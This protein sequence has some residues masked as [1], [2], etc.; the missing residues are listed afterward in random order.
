MLKR[1]LQ[2]EQDRIKAAEEAAV[3]KAAAEAARAPPNSPVVSPIAELSDGSPSIGSSSSKSTTLP[4]R[5]Q[6][7]IS[8][9][10]LHRPPF[11]HKLDLSAATLRLKPDDPMQVLQSGLASPVTLA[12]RSSISLVPPDF[13]FGPGEVEIDLTLDDEVPVNMASSIDPTLGSS[14]DKPIE[15]LDLDMEL[16]G[17]AVGSDPDAGSSGLNV[18]GLTGGATGAGTGT[19]VDTGNGTGSAAKQEEALDFELLRAFE[20]TG[21]SKA[22]GDLLASLSELGSTATGGGSSTGAAAGQSPG[23]LVAGLV[24]TQDGDNAS[25]GGGQFEMTVDFANIM[26]GLFSMDGSTGGGGGSSGS[27]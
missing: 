17:D 5:R 21:P 7:T 24:G 18:A 25:G 11:P 14:A 12:P 1:D 10:S 20:A 3:A 19:G 22:D 8:L 16:F 26:E 23:S 15:L 2:R 27:T 6:S 13:T 9:S 4:A